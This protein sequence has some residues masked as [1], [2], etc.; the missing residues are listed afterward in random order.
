MGTTMKLSGNSSG[1]SPSGHVDHDAVNSANLVDLVLRCVSRSEVLEEWAIGHT[2]ITREY[3]SGTRG[4]S[5]WSGVSDRIVRN[6]VGPT[7]ALSEFK[8]LWTTTR[9][10]SSAIA[11]ERD[12]MELRYSSNTRTDYRSTSLKDP[13]P[14][15]GQGAL[16]PLALKEKEAEKLIK[17]N[18]VVSAR[19]SERGQNVLVKALMTLS[20][21]TEMTSLTEP[22]RILKVLDPG[23]DIWSE[24]E[25]GNEVRTAVPPLGR[26]AWSLAVMCGLEDVVLSVSDIEELT[27]LSKRGVQALLA[28]MTK[29]DPVLVQKVRK[30]R[31]FEYAI[32]WASRFRSSGDYW[33]ICYYDDEIRKARASKDRAVQATSARRGTPAGWIAYK[34]STASPKR[35]EYLATHSLPADAD[36]AW[37]ALVEAGDELELYAYLKAQEAEAGPVPSTPEVLVEE[38]KGSAISTSLLGQPAQESL[39]SPKRIDP[40]VL[41]AMRARICAST[42]A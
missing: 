10:T 14:S 21:L 1:S 39:E 23:L 34:L 30:G 33:G 40:E 35:D 22:G 15:L 36:G 19:I 28:R 38:A 13:S 17:D 12:S 42:Y 16:G 5:R 27:G 4:L 8:F 18:A 25:E 26:R 37:R 9:G 32:C 11:D 29:A 2:V 20:T 3:V 41:A 7:G 31:S 24:V 6:I